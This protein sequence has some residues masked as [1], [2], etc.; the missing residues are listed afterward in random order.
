MTVYWE[1]RRT[2]NYQCYGAINAYYTAAL[3]AVTVSS[4]I[5]MSTLQLKGDI[6]W[7]LNDYAEEPSQIG[8]KQGDSLWLQQRAGNWTKNEINCC[9]EKK[10]GEKCGEGKGEKEV[11]IIGCRE[12]GLLIQMTI[13]LIILYCIF[14]TLRRADGRKAHFEGFVLICCSLHKHVHFPKLLHTASSCLLYVQYN[15][16]IWNLEYLSKI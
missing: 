4:P 7:A 11:G 12:Q 14:N 10:E 8:T 9:L 16:Y 5:K 15:A 1:A 2:G 3:M 6:N 13:Q